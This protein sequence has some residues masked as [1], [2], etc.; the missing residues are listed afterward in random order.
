M[1]QTSPNARSFHDQ[2]IVIDALEHSN[3]DRE[4]L[5]E[6][7]AGG[8]TAIHVTLAVWENCRETLQNISAWHRLFENHGDIVCP[9]R[10]AAE[11]RHAKETGRTAII[12]GFQNSSPIED[13]VGLVQ[14]FHELGVRIMQLTYNNQSL[15]GSSCYEQN[16]SGIPRFGREVIR[17]MNRV[18]MIVDVSHCGERTGFEA[19]EISERPIAITHANPKSFHAGIRNKSDDLIKAVAQS[20]GML[21]FS[22]YPLHIGGRETP[23]E[24][25]CA[26]VAKTAEMVGVEH[27][28]FGTDQSRKW[29]DADL[30]WIRSGRWKKGV[31]FGEGSAA[32]RSW[33]QWPDWFRTP[34]DFP[35]LTE[36]LLK[37]GFN[38]DE[39]AGLM[40]GNWLRFFEDGFQGKAEPAPKSAASRVSAS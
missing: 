26:M 28:G 30:D 32:N 13:D 2:L 39:V 16:D 23:I 6:L 15:I 34:A 4:L 38:R 29:V 31:D 35:N 24:K 27:L 22:L 12:F 21:G 10:S 3:W 36:G 19:V 37:V 7:R 20:G 8:V 17:E 18:G 33:P 5:E 25:F 1:N 11:I 40:G 14:V 9:G